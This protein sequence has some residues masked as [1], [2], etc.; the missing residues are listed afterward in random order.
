MPH[1][2]R[3]GKKKEKDSCIQ[4]KGVELG[5]IRSSVGHVSETLSPRTNA[6]PSQANEPV[7]QMKTRGK[8]KSR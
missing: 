2:D 1:P 5:A 8:E 6:S 7:Q 3:A 4:I